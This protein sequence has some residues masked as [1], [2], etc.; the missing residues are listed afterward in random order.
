MAN[1]LGENHKTNNT[2]RFRWALETATVF[3]CYTVGDL[4][5]NLDPDEKQD[6]LKELIGDIGHLAKHYGLDFPK[7]LIE[8]KTLFDE[9]VAEDPGPTEWSA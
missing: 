6:A 2:D 5:R 4:F 8:G 7:A 1:I 3:T 9:Q